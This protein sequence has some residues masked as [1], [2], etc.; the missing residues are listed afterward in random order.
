M[1]RLFSAFVITSLAIALSAPPFRYL[2]EQSMFWHMAVQMPLLVLGGW[3]SMQ[4]L[5]QLCVL[6]RLAPWNRYGL[7]GFITA[8]VIFAYW[9]L[10]LAID[11]AVVLPLTDLLKLVTLF[12]AGAMLQHSFER[13][14][15]VLQLFFVGYTVSMMTWLGSYFAS[16]DLRLCNAYSLA[17]Q[18][19]TGWGI[20]AIGIALGAAWVV[21]LVWQMRC[22]QQLAMNGSVE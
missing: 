21:R 19:L 7:T 22:E 10:P 11:R 9:M 20:V 1:K 16:T 4:G 17:S 14:P 8:Q 18:V 2:I 13:S 12:V 5:S 3:W 15:A 6:C